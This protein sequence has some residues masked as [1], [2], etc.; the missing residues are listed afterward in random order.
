[1]KQYFS[2]LEDTL[3]QNNL[4]NNPAIM[5]SVDET[6]ML[7]DVKSPNILK[8]K[9]CYWVFNRTSGK[10]GWVTVV[11]YENDEIMKTGIFP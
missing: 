4:L 8:E 11:A 5:Y 10:T 7:L 9:R 1:M 3:K 6:G 2:L